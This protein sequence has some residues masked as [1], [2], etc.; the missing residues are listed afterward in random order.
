MRLR[1][2]ESSPSIAVGPTPLASMNSNTQKERTMRCLSISFALSTLLLATI[3][4][5]QQTAQNT[6]PDPAQQNLPPALGDSNSFLGQGA[7]VANTFGTGHSFIGNAAGS[8]N[9]TGNY[10]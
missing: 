2:F 8:A 6:P 5:A 4:S 9:T 10:N 1:Y 3:C 7:G